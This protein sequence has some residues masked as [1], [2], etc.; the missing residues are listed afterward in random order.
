VKVETTS[1]LELL[2]QRIALLG[3]LSDA[4]LAARTAV[5]SFDLDGLEA[6]IADQNRL[7]GEIR[8]LDHHIE[9]LRFQCA[10][11]PSGAG[12][13]KSVAQTPSHDD[14]GL[15]ATFNRLNQAQV[16]V[17][18]LNDAHQVL[19]GRSRR[20][21]SALLTS[22]H[23]FALTYSDPSSVREPLGARA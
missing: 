15:L 11:S 19:L 7:C 12:P 13:D 21:V 23:S 3:S 4:L 8:S 5:V 6:Q 14:P 10:A 20:T 1:Y 16:R 17:K 18:H 9:Q 22:Y 2:E